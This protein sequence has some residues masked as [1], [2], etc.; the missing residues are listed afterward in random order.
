M[1]NPWFELK[2][3]DDNYC[4]IEPDKCTDIFIAEFS[5]YEIEVPIGRN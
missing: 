1:E 5:D 3:E 4:P 2:I